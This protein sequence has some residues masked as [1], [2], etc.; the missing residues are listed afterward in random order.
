MQFGFSQEIYSSS[1]LRIQVSMLTW[2]PPQWMQ[3]R[4]WY[5]NYTTHLSVGLALAGFSRAL[6]SLLC[7]LWVLLFSICRREAP[8]SA[9]P[10]GSLFEES[11]GWDWRVQLYS[12][13][14]LCFPRAG[15]GPAWKEGGGLIFLHGCG[16][17]S[18]VCC[19]IPWEHA[20]ALLHRHS[21]ISGLITEG[22]HSLWPALTL[23]SPSA[24]PQLD[25]LLCQ[26][27]RFAARKINSSLFSSSSPNWSSVPN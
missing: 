7:R 27:F 25:Y 18:A 26:N 1:T 24:R 6:C 10:V 9:L 20:A 23:A 15:A 19:A 21:A 4:S 2:L 22:W 5:W 13:L 11:S 17:G 8:G 12:L 14:P 16:A 3:E